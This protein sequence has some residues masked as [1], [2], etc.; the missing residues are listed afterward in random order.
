VIPA[1]TLLEGTYQL[2]AAIQDWTQAHDYDYWRHGLRFDVLPS[3]IHEE[4]FISLGGSWR[5]EGMATSSGDHRV[6]A[7]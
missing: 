6:N 4:G 5:L 7:V 2:T 3:T 1:L